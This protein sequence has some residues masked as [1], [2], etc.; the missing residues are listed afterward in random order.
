VCDKFAA[1]KRR[2]AAALYS[3]TTAHLASW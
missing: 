2:Q 1:E 3:E